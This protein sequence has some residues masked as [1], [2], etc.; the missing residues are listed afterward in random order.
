MMATGNSMSSMGQKIVIGG[1]FIQI[2]MF[3]FFGTVAVVFH[4]RYE[5]LSVEAAAVKMQDGRK[6]C[7]CC[8]E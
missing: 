7:S 2:I 4:Y 3:T 1:L 5:H 6:T 8:M